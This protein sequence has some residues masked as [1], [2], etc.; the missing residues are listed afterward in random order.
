M[1]T[2][3]VQERL[4]AAKKELKKVKKVSRHLEMVVDHHTDFNIPLTLQFA[5]DVQMY[6]LYQALGYLLS[7][8]NQDVVHA[9]LDDL[10]I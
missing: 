10:K 6:D 2:K 1:S 4:D 3:T 9:I 5:Q 7:Y 8:T